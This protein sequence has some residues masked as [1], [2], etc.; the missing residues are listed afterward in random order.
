MPAGDRASIAA[1]AAEVKFYTNTLQYQ[2]SLW[3][4]H[5]P[6]YAHNATRW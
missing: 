5:R 3:V 4:R 6:A 2:R 1:Q